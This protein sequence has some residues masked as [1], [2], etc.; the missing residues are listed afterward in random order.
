MTRSRSLPP[1]HS[2]TRL[3]TVAET[4]KFLQLSG[5]TVRRMIARGDLAS[6]RIGRSLRLYEHEV[7]A[8]V[9][10]RRQ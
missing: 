7:H 4:A 8:F 3:V 2:A 10:R 6:Y 1:P 5:R 9:R